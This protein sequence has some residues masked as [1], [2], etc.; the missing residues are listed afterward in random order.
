VRLGSNYVMGV[1]AS[2]Q[3]PERP[4][5]QTHDLEK[6]GWLKLSNENEQGFL[7]SRGGRS[8]FVKRDDRLMAMK[9]L[10]ASPALSFTTCPT[11][12]P[13]I[14]ATEPEYPPGSGLSLPEPEPLSSML[15]WLRLCSSR[16]CRHHRDESHAPGQ[17]CWPSE[18]IKH[19]RQH[20]AAT[21][22]DGF[23][24]H[25]VEVKICAL[26]VHTFLGNRMGGCAP[27]N[28]LTALQSLLNCDR[29]LGA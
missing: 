9:L 25:A 10:L 12:C 29:N 28:P 2:L 24:K 17:Q 7:P 23:R 27:R 22:G 5:V 15:L 14:P 16:L 3:A 19:A 18:V 26:S 4:D 20:A 1:L 6:S 11:I 13:R 8:I 21:N